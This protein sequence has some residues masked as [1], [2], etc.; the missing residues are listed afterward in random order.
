MFLGLDIGTSSAKAILLSSDGAIVGRGSAPY[1]VL[2]PRPGWAETD[3]ETWWIASALAVEQAVNGRTADVKALGLSGQMHG[4]VLATETGRPLRP[5]ILWADTRSDEMLD[6][7]VSLGEETHHRLANPYV[8]GMAGPS[9]LWIRDHEPDVFHAARWAFLPKDWLRFRLTGEAASEPSD[10]SATLL[11]DVQRDSWA[12][13]IITRL[14][15]R[16]DFLPALTNSATIAGR[17]TA[18]AAHHLGL[19]RGLPVAAGA[20]DTAAAMI[21]T[22]LIRPGDVQLTVGTGGQIASCLEHPTPDAT[23]RTHLFRTA[24]PNQWY[25]MAALQNVGIALEW[26]RRQFA[27]TWEAFYAEASMVAAGAEGCRFLPY[28]TTERSQ[29]EAVARGGTWSGIR[30][31]HGRGHLLRAALEGVAFLLRDGLAM[32]E[33]RGI[34]ASELR[35]AGGGTLEPMWRQ[36]LSDVLGCP[37]LVLPDTA[38]SARGAALIAAVSV[39][40]FGNLYET[41]TVAPVPLTTV[42]PGSDRALYRHAHEGDQEQ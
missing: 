36:M 1:Q 2:S 21:G 29:H 40:A 34:V 11:Y 6:A 31:H 27:V 32:M 22:G 39:G 14:H 37:L 41:A 18:D 7:Y 3:P 15:V 30:L 12:T 9:L 42:S 28:L 25:A 17:L 5:A 23:Y 10:A 13:E 24:C 33:D 16:C 38:A 4:V 35:L 8:P 20:A 26:V 19:P